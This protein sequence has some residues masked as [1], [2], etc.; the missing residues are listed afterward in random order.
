MH[1]V[2]VT[3]E[4]TGVYGVHDQSIDDGVCAGGH[5]ERGC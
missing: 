2:M 1:S 5:S 4:L 3:I